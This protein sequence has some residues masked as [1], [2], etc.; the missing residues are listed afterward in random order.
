MSVNEQVAQ[1]IKISLYLSHNNE[2]FD[3]YGQTSQ[4]RY[5]IIIYTSINNTLCIRL[6]IKKYIRLND[7]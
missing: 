3:I 6:R 4:M 1:H 7:F 2:E 5:L